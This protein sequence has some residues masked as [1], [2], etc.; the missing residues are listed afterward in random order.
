M[1]AKEKRTT[2]FGWYAVGLAGLYVLWLLVQAI[3]FY[4]MEVHH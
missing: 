1:K 4:M 3:G 2:D